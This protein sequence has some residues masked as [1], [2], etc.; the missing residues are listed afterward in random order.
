[1][2]ARHTYAQ[3]AIVVAMR[4]FHHGALKRALLDEA[5]ALLDADGPDVISLRDLARRVGVSPR[6]P[7]RHFADRD[8]LL[9]AL[10][11]EAFVAFGRALAA[12]DSAAAPG[13]E[14]EEQAI[15]YVRFALAAPGRFRL[16]FS[17]RFVAPPEELVA[18]KQAA[19]GVLK[20]RVDR[21]ASP[22]DDRQAQA[23][24]YWSLAH[25]LAVLSLDDRISDELDDLKGDE[26]EIVR[27]VSAA[28][29]RREQPEKPSASR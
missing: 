20:A 4:T 11:V 28:M 24:G 25:G 3:G 1:M 7:Y 8:A 29:L 17:V 5:A 15:A 27:R 16:M 9:A 22:G 12:A 19:F 26:D 21:R 2:Y 10:A 23:V 13:R 6:A 14:L 18:A